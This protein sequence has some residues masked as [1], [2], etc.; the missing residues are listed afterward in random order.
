MKNLKIFRAGRGEG[1]TKWLFEQAVNAYDSGNSCYFCGNYES[2]K[3]IW[4]AARHETCPVKHMTHVYNIDFADEHT[5]LFVD[6][7]LSNEL[8]GNIMAC[9]KAFDGAKWYVTMD[10][11]DFVN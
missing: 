3:E 8:S 11:D 1:K 10:A 4:A 6:D 7:V 5:C 2:F 9:M